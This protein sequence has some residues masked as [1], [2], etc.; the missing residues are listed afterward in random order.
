MSRLVPFV[1][2]ALW[3]SIYPARMLLAH[4]R[5]ATNAYDLSFFDYA[6]WNLDQG[7][8]VPFVA[9]SIFSDHAMPTLAALAPFYALAP[10]PATLIVFQAVA[11]L[12]AAL[13]LIFLLR[14]HV[15]PLMT[16]ALVF[17]F[18]FGRR[19]H[20]ATMN[21]YYI[22]SLEPA[23]ILGMVLAWQHR[24][25][26][27]YAVCAALAL[28][29]KEDM[30]IYVAMFGLVMWKRGEHRRIALATV[31][32][33]LV[34]V[35]LALAVLVPVSRQH[36][37]LAPGN[38]LWEQRFPKPVVTGAIGR[39]ISNRAAVEVFQLMATTGFAAGGGWQWLLVAFPGAMANIA[40]AWSQQQAGLTGHYFW[41]L[42]PWL[43]VAA[44]AGARRLES[45]NRRYAIMFA[46]ALVTYISIDSPL[47]QT[48][49]RPTAVTAE[50]AARIERVLTAI[51]ADASLT[52]TGNL[53]PH[54]PH[55]D[56]IHT[57]GV[58]E[59]IEATDYIALS[60]SGNSWPLD[61]AQVGARIACLSDDARFERVGNGDPAI[62]RRLAPA[63]DLPK[64]GAATSASPTQ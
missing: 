34:W 44:G 53:V 4:Q 31:G 11:V 49:S 55:R 26:A 8:F 46:A 19:S 47:W 54:V 16:A 3:L 57:F 60:A 32:V 37:G 18:L 30:A 6:L 20:S 14:Q 62:F 12:A 28:G 1:P 36:D 63:A 35:I 39:A 5:F 23:L 42:L 43:F 29:C 51:P 2:V 17:A 24:R 33:A 61:S 40:S 38:R 15:S 41:P 64:C 10:G 22:E 45:A 21:L 25:F 13:L 7:G 59:P 50:D 27:W 52:A 9:R 48:L 58:N 56:R